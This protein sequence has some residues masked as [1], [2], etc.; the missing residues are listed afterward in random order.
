MK[1]RA[2]ELIY[3]NNKRVRP[4][5]VVYLKDEKHFSEKSMEKLKA[6]KAYEP[7]I[8]EEE[9]ENETESVSDQEVI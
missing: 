5:Q 2:K 8:E 4:G 6:K 3:Y 7:E 9:I 1:V